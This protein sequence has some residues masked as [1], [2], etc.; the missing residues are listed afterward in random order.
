MLR[1]PLGGLPGEEITMLLSQGLVL[2]VAGVS[3]VFL[4]LGL[5]VAVLSV[6]AKIIPR[7][8]HVLPD[9]RPR[10]RAPKSAL[11]REPTGDEEIAVAVAAAVAHQRDMGISK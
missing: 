11:P 3:I 7:F 2:M 4:F 6:S 8:N 5:L 10:V 1:M 9:E